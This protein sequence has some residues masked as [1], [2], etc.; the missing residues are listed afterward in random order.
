MTTYF[1]DSS[2]STLLNS[3]NVS[4]IDQILYFVQVIIW[5][6]V[7]LRKLWFHFCQLI[8]ILSIDKAFYKS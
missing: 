7:D 6:I 3:F 1:H 4:L 8:H 2:Y 5:D